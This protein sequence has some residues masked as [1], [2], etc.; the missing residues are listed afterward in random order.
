MRGDPVTALR[1]AADLVEEAR[2]AEEDDRA[3]SRRLLGEAHALLRPIIEELEG[4]LE[5]DE[6]DPAGPV[7]W[8]KPQR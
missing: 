4:A 1:R 6:E 2:R 8:R 5:G 3:R 7:V